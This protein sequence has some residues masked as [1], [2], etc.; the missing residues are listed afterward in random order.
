MDALKKENKEKAT[1]CRYTINKQQPFNLNKLRHETNNNERKPNKLFSSVVNRPLSQFQS[2]SHPSD[3]KEGLATQMAQWCITQKQIIHDSKGKTQQCHIR[4][5]GLKHCELF[6][7]L[8][9]IIK[10]HNE[11]KTEICF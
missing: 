4:K 11:A 6:C 9:Y 10:G 1:N 5:Q 2:R 8:E 3:N 7:W